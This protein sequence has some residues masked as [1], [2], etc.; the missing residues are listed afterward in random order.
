MRIQLTAIL[1]SAALAAGCIVQM[2]PQG[3]PHATEGDGPRASE[4]GHGGD[5][6]GG[7]G[8]VVTRD[9]R[10]GHD[11]ADSGRGGPPPTP[12]TY[13]DDQGTEV[14]F[15]LGDQAF[16]TRVVSFEMGSPP[17]TNPAYTDPQVIIGPP[18]YRDGGAAISLGC[19]GRITV[20][21]D[22]VAL[23][24]GPG[25]DLHI[26]EIGGAI[27]SMLVEISS[28]GRHWKEVGVVRG[29]PASVDIEAVARPGARYPFVRITDQGDA[30]RG[31]TA[32]ADIDAVGLIHGR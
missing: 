6:Q 15:E 17:A 12:R 26:F 8:G 13:T 22:D 10:S 14:T 24:D 32:G 20:A 16:A 4:R 11:G 3:G 2:E 21:F 29:Q 18:N 5:H 1:G 28:D 27:E 25:N 31:R 7:E 30:C 19:K 9:H 23:V